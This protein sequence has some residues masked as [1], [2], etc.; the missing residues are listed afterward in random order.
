M[1]VFQKDH[2]FPAVICQVLFAVAS[3]SIGRLSMLFVIFFF[4]LSVIN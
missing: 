3:R 4:K 2:L 1:H